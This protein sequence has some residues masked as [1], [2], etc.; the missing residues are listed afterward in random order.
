MLT[1]PSIQARESMGPWQ[2][3][4]GLATVW[5]EFRG[6]QSCRMAGL[7]GRGADLGSERAELGGTSMRAARAGVPQSPFLPYGP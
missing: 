3:C 1:T 5:P 2:G 4:A 6:G 7:G